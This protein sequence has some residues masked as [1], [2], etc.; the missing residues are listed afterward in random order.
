MS[1]NR[2][3][4]LAPNKLSKD[5]KK[6]INTIIKTDTNFKKE[7]KV[8]DNKIN[9]FKKKSQN[10]RFN[11]EHENDDDRNKKAGRENKLQL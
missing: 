1:N 10:K 11:F 6:N 5:N 3:S 2:F 8:E 7:D 9:M 4:I